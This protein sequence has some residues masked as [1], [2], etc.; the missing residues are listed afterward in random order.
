MYRKASKVRD[1]KM[2]REHKRRKIRKRKSPF[3]FERTGARL[4]ARA[5]V[6]IKR[7]EHISGIPGATLH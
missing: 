2:N 5:Y 4:V 3:S 6:E 7:N 1:K